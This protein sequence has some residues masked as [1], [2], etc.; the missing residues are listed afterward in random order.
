MASLE[1]Q[2][3]AEER[4]MGA[5]KSTMGST[6]EL[7]RGQ[8]SFSLSA[9]AQT[10][11]RDLLIELVRPKRPCRSSHVHSA[12]DLDAEDGV[13]GVP[14]SDDHVLVDGSARTCA[15]VVNAEMKTD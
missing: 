2:W 1:D 15:E 10:H 3:K 11:R 14:P 12:E 9:K 7:E 4:Y 6:C 8:L 13:E 5:S